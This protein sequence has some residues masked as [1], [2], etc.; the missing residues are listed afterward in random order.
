[1]SREQRSYISPRV[2]RRRAH[3]AQPPNIAVTPAPGY[4]RRAYASLEDELR[5]LYP[6]LSSPES[7][8]SELEFPGFV[9]VNEDEWGNLSMIIPTEN[10]YF[11][12]SP[13]ASSGRRRRRQSP[14]FSP[15]QGYAPHYLGV[16]QG[17]EYE[18]LDILTDIQP[19]YIEEDDTGAMD[20]DTEGMDVDTEG[21]EL[22]P[23]PR[24]GYFYF[25]ASPRSSRNN[26]TT[27][28]RRRR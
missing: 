22:S 25:E 24:Q 28:R 21:M 23:I 17:Q 1:M 13:A 16:R 5:A 15:V 11:E 14:E 20:V 7:P 8:E 3:R 9:G 4:R 18:D 27:R 12:A 10:Y 2:A 26:S 19:V 6:E